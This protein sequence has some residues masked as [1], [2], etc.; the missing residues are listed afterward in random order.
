MTSDQ[1]KNVAQDF[2]KF[3]K[4]TRASFADGT[5]LGL[6]AGLSYQ[7]SLTKSYNT[8]SLDGNPGAVARLLDDLNKQFTQALAKGEE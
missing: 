8:T 1:L 2:E 5:F 4:L 3:V 6:V 7:D